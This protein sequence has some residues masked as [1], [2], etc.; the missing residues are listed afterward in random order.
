MRPSAGASRLRTR[1]AA[2]KLMWASKTSYRNSDIG[3]RSHGHSLSLALKPAQ[4][5]WGFFE[6]LLGLVAFGIDSDELLA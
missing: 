4:A 5:V 2:R 1:Q 3:L 6:I